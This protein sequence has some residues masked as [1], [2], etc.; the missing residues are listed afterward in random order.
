MLTIFS[1]SRIHQHFVGIKK[2]TM[3]TSLI[4]KSFNQK[5]SYT[6]FCKKY[7]HI[8]IHLAFAQRIA[9]LTSR[10]CYCQSEKIKAI[11]VLEIQILV[12]LSTSSKLINKHVGALRTGNQPIFTK[13]LNALHT[14][15]YVCNS[16]THAVV[17]KVG[18]A[19]L[20]YSNKSLRT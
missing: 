2:I 5:C 12:A 15:I 7:R 8:F 1:R 17:C 4:I 16:N 18:D 20:S 3:K 6:I 14:Q 19:M 11:F 9:N 10:N 13:G